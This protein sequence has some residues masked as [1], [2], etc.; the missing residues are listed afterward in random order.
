MQN[1]NYYIID[2]GK[3]TFNNYK[4]ELIHITSKAN[5]SFDYNMLKII[6]NFN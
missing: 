3:N 5:L 6:P 1:P 4:K 2:D